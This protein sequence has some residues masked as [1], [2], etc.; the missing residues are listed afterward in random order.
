MGGSRGLA[1]PP[2][3]RPRLPIGEGGLPRTARSLPPRWGP[4]AGPA[5]C[6]R[7]VGMVR[8]VV[9]AAVAASLVRGQGGEDD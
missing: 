5:A 4:P 2:I 8:P 1:W 9:A 7:E 3:G 6:Q